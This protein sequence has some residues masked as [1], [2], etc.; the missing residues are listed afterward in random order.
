MDE[1][2]LSNWVPFSLYDFFGYIIPGSILLTGLSLYFFNSILQSQIYVNIANLIKQ[3]GTILR[4][5]FAIIGLII[6]YSVGH[7]VATISHIIFDRILVGSILQYPYRTLLGLE[8]TRNIVHPLNKMILLAFILS[9]I[10]TSL[11]P[12]VDWIALSMVILFW[13]A[14]GLLILI[15]LLLVVIKSFQT[16]FNNPNESKYN[17]VQSKKIYSTKCFI[18][19][20]KIKPFIEA[21]I[22]NITNC[23]MFAIKIIEQLIDAIFIIPI[24]K[25]ISIEH[26]FDAKFAEKL[27]KLIEQKFLIICE[28]ADSNNIWLT[29]LLLLDKTESNKIIKNWLHLYGLNRNISIALFMLSL[30]GTA[31]KFYLHHKCSI[32]SNIFIGITA[33][34]SIFFGFRY[35]MLYYTYYSKNIFRLFY[36][37]QINENKEKKI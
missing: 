20:H 22:S 28:S 17:T 16:S 26:K 1:Q 5:I 4:I 12:W 21:S 29:S 9:W 27:K 36:L 31:N 18:C 33:I 2:K 32:C 7:I 8:K 30:L 14:T 11:Q 37:D 35:I 34:S 10:T 23:I 24:K 3:S 13:N 25:L 15:R 19:F 6:T